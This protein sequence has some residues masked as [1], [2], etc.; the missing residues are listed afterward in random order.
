LARSVH[1]RY[2]EALGAAIE[3]PE[4]LYPGDYL[5]PVGQALAA[6]FG[7][8]Y[9]RYAKTVPPFVPHL[10]R[11]LGAKRDAGADQR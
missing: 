11:L 3:I 4:G 1:M 8:A 9:R 5:I 10:A 2:L 7:D 6:E